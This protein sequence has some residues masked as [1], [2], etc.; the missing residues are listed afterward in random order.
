MLNKIKELFKPNT[1]WKEKYDEKR[2]E[3]MNWEC[4][5]NTLHRQLAAILKER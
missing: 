4:K 2:K 1:D 5:Y 3:S